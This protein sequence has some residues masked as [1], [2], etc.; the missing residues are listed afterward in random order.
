MSEEKKDFLAT[1]RERYKRAIEADED[2]WK[3]ALEVLKF[4]NGEHWPEKIKNDRMNDP[5]GSRPCEVVDKTEQHLN[6]ICN[7]ERQNRPSIKVRPVDDI[8]DPEV[9]EVFQGLVRHIEDRSSADVAYDTAYEQAADAGFGYFRVLTEYSDPMQFDQDIVIK[10]IRNRFQVVLDPDR[11]EPDGSDAKFAFIVEKM[12]KEEYEAA[13]GDEHPVDFDTEG[14]TFE[15]WIE[16]EHVLVAEY[17][18]IEYE[19]T[20]ICRYTDGKVYRSDRPIPPEAGMKVLNERGKPIERKTRIPTVKWSKINGKEEIE[21]RDWAGKYIPIIEVIGKELDIEGKVHKS[22][23]LKNAMGPQRM[24]DYSASSFIENVALAP[25]APWTA[26]EGQLEGHEHDWRTANRRNLSVLT[27]KPVLLDGNV[28]VPPP[29]RLPAP[30]IPVGWQQAL[31]NSEHDIQA[32]MGRYDAS[33]GADS[34]E[35]SGVALQKKQ[36]ESDTATFHYQDNL[37]RSIRHCGR[38][39]IDLIPKIYDTRR[40]A[41]ILGEDGSTDQVLLDPG[42]DRPVMDN[43]EPGSKIKKIYNLNV[44]KYDVT[45][46][47]GPSYTTKRQ[48]A[49]DQMVQVLTAKPELLNIIG[50]LA[51]RNMDWPGSDQIADRLKKMLPPQLQESEDDDEESVVPTPQGPITASQ[52]A[53]M[54]EGLTMELQQAQEALQK[55]GDL[56][57]L[58]K[59]VHDEAHR[60]ELDKKDVAHAMEKMEMQAGGAGG[61]GGPQ[62]RMGGGR[63]GQGGQGMGMPGI[64]VIDS[65][66]AAPLEAVAQGVMAVAQAVADQGPLLLEVA[67][68]TEAA[69]KASLAPRRNQ[70]ILDG[71]LLESISQ[72]VV[73]TLQ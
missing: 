60:V 59:A 44:G 34:N 41:R 1:A 30:G 48:E 31:M 61:Q 43:P 5:E 15:G 24:H 64:N 71:E 46:S 25:R 9:A 62:G 36:R 49:A 42:L 57:E 10:R 45:V 4:R 54:L 19:E 33:L 12:K 40:V 18:R 52:A 22:G 14:K 2:N 32:A 17:F 63:M 27:Y 16:K 35:K 13:Y 8:G 37:S 29:T 58:S 11:Q 66:A 65:T 53:Q 39:L 26:A 7:D 28:Q 67:R 51:F 56:E 73:E 50:D 6:Q 68:A 70:M 38:I 21:K 20:T 3:H 47:V 72:P 55:A 23:L 69:A